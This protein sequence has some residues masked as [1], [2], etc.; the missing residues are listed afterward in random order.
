MGFR[1][2]VRGYYGCRKGTIV[3]CARQRIPCAEVVRRGRFRVFSSRIR[4]YTGAMV[5]GRFSA[6]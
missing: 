5:S 6:R 4:G 2:R 1:R 3:G